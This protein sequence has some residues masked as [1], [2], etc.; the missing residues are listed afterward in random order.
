METTRASFLSLSRSTPPL[1]M[2]YLLLRAL[3]W[4]GA[5]KRRDCDGDEDRDKDLERAAQM[6]APLS[7]IDFLFL[8]GAQSHTRLLQLNGSNLWMISDQNHHQTSQPL[9]GCRAEASVL[10]P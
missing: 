1:R 9:V 2:L 3:I 10:L 5:R 4:C 7:Y 8:R 6:K